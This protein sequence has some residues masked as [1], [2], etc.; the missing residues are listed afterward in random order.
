MN[1]QIQPR[2]MWITVLA[3]FV[4]LLLFGI[5][6]QFLTYLFALVVGWFILYKLTKGQSKLSFKGLFD[7]FR[8]SA[9]SGFFAFMVWRILLNIINIIR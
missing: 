3:Q 2:L 4:I 7:A 5:K 9:L 8:V 6:G 1:N